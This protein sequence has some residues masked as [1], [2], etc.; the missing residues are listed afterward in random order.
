VNLDIGGKPTP[1]G[2]EPPAGQRRNSR[3]TEAVSTLMTTDGMAPSYCSAPAARDSSEPNRRRPTRLRSRRSPRQGSEQPCPITGR[4]R[5][6]VASWTHRN[7][8]FIGPSPMD[9]GAA[10]LIPTRVQRTIWSAA[11][12]DT[13]HPCTTP[14]LTARPGA[15]SLVSDLQPPEGVPSRIEGRH[16]F[17]VPPPPAPTG[18][19]SLPPLFYRLPQTA[20]PASVPGHERCREPRTRGDCHFNSRAAAGLS[21]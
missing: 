8:C 6:L 11:A 12:P 9:F 21:Q 18:L 2:A 19:A 7:S 3:R 17:A 5:P 16:C 14:V 1:R 4:R 15:L 20:N 13:A 10:I